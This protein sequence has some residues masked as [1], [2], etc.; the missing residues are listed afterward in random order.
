MSAELQ[1]QLDA[2]KQWIAKLEADLNTKSLSTYSLDLDDAN[3]AK[4]AAERKL[5]RALE[6]LAG[7]RK[8]FEHIQNCQRPVHIEHELFIFRLQENASH[9]ICN[10]DVALA[11]IEQP[12][13]TE[14]SR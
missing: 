8:R 1:Q 4:E 6:I 9:A 13:S 14:A 2:A 7:A 11:E 3:T 5:A 10:L 12:Q